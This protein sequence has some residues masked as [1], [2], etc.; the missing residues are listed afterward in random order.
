MPLW[1]IFLFLALL[2]AGLVLGVGTI[3]APIR[4]RIILDEDGV[5]EVGLL[6]TRRLLYSEI[7]EKMRVPAKWPTW[8][9]VPKQRSKRRVMFEMAY[10]FDEAF[11]NWFNATPRADK[12]FWKPMRCH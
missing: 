2:W 10:K 8:A 3:I 11:Y 12:D 1:R 4:Q 9:L 5:E 6:F 7:G